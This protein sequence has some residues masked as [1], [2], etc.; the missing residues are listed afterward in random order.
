MPV[1][2][3]FPFLPPINTILLACALDKKRGGKRLFPYTYSPTTVLANSSVCSKVT[4]GV[5]FAV[6]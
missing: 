5:I 1:L 3:F 6:W 4:T 2:G